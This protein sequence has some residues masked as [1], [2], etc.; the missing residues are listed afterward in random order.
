MQQGTKRGRTVRKV[1]KCAKLGEK[2][3]LFKVREVMQKAHVVDVRD[4]V[5][6]PDQQTNYMQKD[7]PQAGEERFASVVYAEDGNNR[8]ECGNARIEGVELR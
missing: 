6:E 2:A 1:A 5:E 4:D 3:E 8:K 7:F